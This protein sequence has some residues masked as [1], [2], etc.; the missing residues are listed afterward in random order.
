V[1]KRLNIFLLGS[2]LAF[3]PFSSSF[4]TCGF[5]TKIWGE[6]STPRKIVAFTTNVW[7]MKGISTT[8]EI[9]GCGPE[10]NI[11]KRA[12]NEKVRYYAS[13]NLDHLASQFA[14]GQGEHLDAIAYLI[15]IR[16]EDLKR[17]H[18]LAQTNFES[19]FPSDHVTADEMLYNLRQ[20][21]IEDKI[22]SSYVE[23]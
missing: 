16:D 19:L 17:F 14:R 4:A 1:K 11:F 13:Q 18:A 23:V 22:L 7:T 3:A 9:S 6:S 5:G 2:I 8:S 21:M 10:D 20:L 15:R 12:S